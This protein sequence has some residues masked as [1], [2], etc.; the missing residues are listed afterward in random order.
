MTTTQTSATAANIAHS[1]TADAI[2]YACSVL[3]QEWGDYGY[4]I[5]GVHGLSWR[6]DAA[7]IVVRAA[8]GSRF[9]I[10]ADSARGRYVYTDGDTLDAVTT[11]A[12][13]LAAS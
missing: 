9:T 12:E 2:R 13:K 3:S 1:V 11:A 10:A 5:I 8:D 4:S 6:G 7:A